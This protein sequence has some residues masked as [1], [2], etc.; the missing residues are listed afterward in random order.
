[1][2]GPTSARTKE[3]EGLGSFP[4]LV[5][6][7]I[8]KEQSTI[9]GN[10]AASGQKLTLGLLSIIALEVAPFRGYSPF[11]ALLPISKRI[12]EVVFFECVQRRLRF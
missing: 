3:M 7:R 8:Y 4:A 1:M 6:T 2:L 12:M 5:Q 9:S 11:P 10:C